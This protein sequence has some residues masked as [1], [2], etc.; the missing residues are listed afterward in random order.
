MLSCIGLPY[1]DGGGGGGV[2]DGG[3]GGGEDIPAWPDLPTR[4]CGEQGQHLVLTASDTLEAGTNQSL[5]AINQSID[6]SM[7]PI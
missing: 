4:F 3:M 1:C 2:T 7:T 5:G 6:Q